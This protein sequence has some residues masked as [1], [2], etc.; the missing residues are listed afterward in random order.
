VAPGS[1]RAVTVLVFYHSL[2]ASRNIDLKLKDSL[3]A[4]AC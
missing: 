1:A 3:R 4:I 2:L